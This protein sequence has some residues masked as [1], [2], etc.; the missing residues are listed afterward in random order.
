[1]SSKYSRW[2]NVLIGLFSFTL[3]VIFYN[4]ISLNYSLPTIVNFIIA[5]LVVDFTVRTLMHFVGV[6]KPEKF[7]ESERK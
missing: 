3:G 1:M 7:D 2:I 6:S 5:L 4:F